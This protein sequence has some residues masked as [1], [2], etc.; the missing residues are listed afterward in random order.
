MQAKFSP[1]WFSGL[2]ACFVLNN[3]SFLD[4]SI[5]QI[6][7]LLPPLFF[8]SSQ[9]QTI[10]QERYLHFLKWVQTRA[11]WV[12]SPRGCQQTSQPCPKTWSRNRGIWGLSQWVQCV[13]LGG[14]SSRRLWSHLLWAFVHS[15]SELGHPW[16][17]LPHSLQTLY[18]PGHA[19]EESGRGGTG[20][21]A[22][23]KVV[24][25]LFSPFS[26]ISHFSLIPSLLR[27][28][29]SSLPSLLL[30]LLLCFSP[31]SLHSPLPVLLSSYL[32]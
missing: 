27:F 13:I 19:A 29:L 26:S 25:L 15:F 8:L 30:P 7:H 12:L 22:T 14:G 18:L 23:G 16:L 2:F 1:A 17:R 5:F 3:C 20:E 9:G 6:R 32:W 28:S 11:G 4:W 24:H 31:S 10:T 21:G